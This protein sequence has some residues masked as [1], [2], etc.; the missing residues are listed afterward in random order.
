M[1]IEHIPIG[2]PGKFANCHFSLCRCYLSFTAYCF[3]VSFYQL[4]VGANYVSDLDIVHCFSRLFCFLVDFPL[5]FYSPSLSL[6]RCLYCISTSS[7][8]SVAFPTGPHHHVPICSLCS[9]IFPQ[10]RRRWQLWRSV[11]RMTNE[12]MCTVTQLS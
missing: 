3:S 2:I 5:Q 1:R 9:F 4:P 8:S 12:N 11:V 7:K 10:P 6:F